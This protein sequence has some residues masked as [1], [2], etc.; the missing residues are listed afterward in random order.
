[1]RNPF[2]NKDVKVFDDYMVIKRRIKLDSL[3]FRTLRPK[4]KIYAAVVTSYRRTQSYRNTQELKIMKM[5]Q[6][7]YDL[8][9]D[10]VTYIAE[11]L[12]ANYNDSS[13]KTIQLIIRPNMVFLLPLLEGYFPE[14]KVTIYHAL[15]SVSALLPL[16]SI[17][18]FSK[19]VIA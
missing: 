9:K 16:P 1:M 11:F 18:R 17:V 19:K 14:W 15:P 12:N 4:E 7:K 2:L 10:G 8:L 5:N 13:P 3:N 6:E